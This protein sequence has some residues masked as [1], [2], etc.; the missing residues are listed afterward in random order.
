MPPPGTEP[1]ALPTELTNNEPEALPILVLLKCSSHGSFFAAKAKK[2]T[3]FSEGDACNQD[4]KRQVRL[5]SHR[6]RRRLSAPGQWGFR[7]EPNSTH[8]RNESRLL[9]ASLFMPEVRRMR[10]E[11]CSVQM[12][13]E[14]IFVGV[15]ESPAV[16]EGIFLSR[17]VKI[18]V[19]ISWPG[20]RVDHATL[21][22]CGVLC[23]KATDE[24]P[25]ETTQMR[26]IMNELITTEVI[27]Q[28][29]ELLLTIIDSGLSRHANKL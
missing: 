8:E 16:S 9:S 22:S 28:L 18:A 3:D 20:P 6:L 2:H 21:S 15:A 4:L 29:P 23:E 27:P 25:E 1:D 11:R 10:I 24:M 26:Q 5:A 14:S 7:V 19:K 17:G 13:I 12:E